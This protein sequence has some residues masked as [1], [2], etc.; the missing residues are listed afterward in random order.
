MYVLMSKWDGTE[1]EGYYLLTVSV[2][3]PVNETPFDTA[4][5]VE[6][7]KEKNHHMIAMF[8]HTSRHMSHC[9][10]QDSKSVRGYAEIFRLLFEWTK[11]DPWN[12]FMDYDTARN[13]I[14]KYK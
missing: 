3:T 2:Q 7:I 11:T 8:W 4:Q 12:N 1:P 5:H 14:N 6:K 13:I 10:L 9:A